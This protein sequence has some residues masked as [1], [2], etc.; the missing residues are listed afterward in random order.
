MPPPSSAPVDL[1][2]DTFT[3]PDAAMRRV[4]AEAEVGD[5]VWGEDPTV[6]R[7]EEEMAGRLGMEAAVFVPSGT[8]GNLASLA[9]QT[10]PGDEV[11]IDAESH[12]VA[13][14]AGGAGAVAGVILHS[15]DAA[16]GAPT[17]A[18]V[19]AAV[20]LPD[21]HHP[22]SRLL[23]LENTHGGRAGLA[24]PARSID[25]A[26]AVAHQAGLRVHCDGARLFNAAV[27]LGVEASLLVA[28]CD[29]VSVCLS[30]GLGAPVGSVVSGDVACITSVRLWRKRLGGGMRQ[31]GILAA[32]G[33]YALDHNV[34]RLADDHANAA[35]LA[36]QLRN[37]AGVSVVEVTVPTNMVMFDTRL[38]AEEVTRLA[39]AAG[40]LLAPVGE[41]RLRCVT[42]KDVDA[43]HVSRAATTLSSVLER[44]LAGGRDREQQ[45]A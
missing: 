36:A 10:S 35:V 43:A 31:A 6:R 37:T 4:M 38:P 22:V 3:T 18:Q 1:R 26:S 7:L 40:V 24:V 27:A 28:G 13:N 15:V 5:D 2:S 21:I 29:T 8:M 23:W 20:R 42:H 12:V 19:A 33:L 16:A 9:A 45:P 30:K 39:A 34:Q 17:A 25:A 11:I 44:V 32:A 41:H 14:E